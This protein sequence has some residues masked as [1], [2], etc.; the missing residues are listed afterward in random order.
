VIVRACG[1]ALVALACAAGTA[2]ANVRIRSDWTTGARFTKVRTLTVLGLPAGSRIELRC[3]GR[4][5]SF[6]TKAIDPRDAPQISLARRVGKRLTARSAIEVRVTVPDVSIT[7]FDFTMRR[8]AQPRRRSFV[9]STPPPPAE[10]PP[11][12]QELATPPSDP[13]TIPAGTTPTPF[14]TQAFGVAKSQL[15]VQF[16]WGGASPETGFD[17]AGLVQYAYAQVGVTLPRNADQQYGVGDAVSPDKLVPGDLVFFTDASG[18]VS[19]VGLFAGERQLIHAPHTGDVVK[20]TS[21]DEPYYKQNYAGARHI[22][23]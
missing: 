18:Y 17:S 14:A 19:H 13:P 2:T 11:P 7:V 6:Q 12:Q 15:G 1:V 9:V 20:Y 22:D 4:G 8:G 16:K 5:C 3:R 21:M 23:G 10:P